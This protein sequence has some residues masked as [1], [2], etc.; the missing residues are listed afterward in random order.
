MAANDPDILVPSAA[1]TTSGSSA[2]IGGLSGE[3]LALG[4]HVTTA[5]G[6]TPSMTLTLKWSHDGTTFG[7]PDA[8]AQTFT[9][10]T[11][12]R[13]AYLRVNVLGPYLRVD[14]AITG[15]TPSFTFSITAF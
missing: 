2:V 14:W 11:A 8:G 4:V 7:D 3:F 6:T 1:R 9:A 5:T 12:A 13:E 10:I 15:T